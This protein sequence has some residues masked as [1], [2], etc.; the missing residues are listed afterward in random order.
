MTGLTTP[1]R[2]LLLQCTA[3]QNSEDQRQKLGPALYQAEVSLPLVLFAPTHTEKTFL[4]H[5]NLGF[6]EM[7][8]QKEISGVVGVANSHIRTIVRMRV[9]CV[10]YTQYVNKS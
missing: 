5:K 8:D 2:K 3:V 1:C 9:H 6:L 7:R 4:L 10:T